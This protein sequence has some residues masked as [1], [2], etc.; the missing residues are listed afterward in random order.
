MTKRITMWDRYWCGFCQQAVTAADLTFH[1]T[2]CAAQAPDKARAEEAQRMAP[3]SVK[4]LLEAQKQMVRYC[5]KRTW[6][7]PKA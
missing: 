1:R 2:N 7:K 5:Q 3:G 4:L 6:N